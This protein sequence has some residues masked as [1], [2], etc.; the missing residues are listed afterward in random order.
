MYHNMS[1]STQK[2]K[3]RSLSNGE[4]TPSSPPRVLTTITYSALPSYRNSQSRNLP[5]S[6][7]A[8]LRITRQSPLSVQQ[9][10]WCWQAVNQDPTLQPETSP[11]AFPP[12]P[13]QKPAHTS[14]PPVQAPIFALTQRMEAHEALGV[15]HRF[16]PHPLVDPW[17]GVL[18][19]FSVSGI[20]MVARINFSIFLDRVVSRWSTR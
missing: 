11:T 15:V 16:A 20:L 19:A 6:I 8:Y 12:P 18:S 1:F 10:S 13:S 9:C 5:R 2:S 7:H 14:R 4:H 3:S 17:F